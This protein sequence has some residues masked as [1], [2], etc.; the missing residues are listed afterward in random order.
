MAVWFESRPA[1]CRSGWMGH[2]C[3]QVRREGR[4]AAT[5]GSKRK[6]C[7]IGLSLVT[8]R[9]AKVY[10]SMYHKNQEEQHMA[11]RDA[12][13]PEFDHEMANT[14]KTLERV[15]DD[16]FG[17]KPHEKSSAMGGLAAHL[18]NLPSWAGL[19]ISQDSLDLAPG[20]EPVRQP[21]LNTQSEVLATFD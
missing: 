18:A 16:K 19:T 6:K 17:W 4:P 10:C 15:P 13:L 8:N 20:G 21:P 2:P 3:K 11:I 14:R 5:T 12:L 1:C 9:S 7:R